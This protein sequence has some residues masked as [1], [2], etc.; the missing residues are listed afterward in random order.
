MPKNRKEGF[1]GHASLQMTMDLYTH[2]LEKQKQDDMEKL[3]NVLDD[4][5]VASDDITERVFEKMQAQE[6]N[7]VQLN[8]G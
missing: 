2:V 6:N 3:E 5:L 7:V 1:L 4:I 8:V